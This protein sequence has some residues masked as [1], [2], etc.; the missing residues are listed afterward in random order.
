M[1]SVRKNTLDCRVNRRDRGYAGAEYIEGLSKEIRKKKAR[2]W[3]L[4]NHS[5]GFVGKL[6][7]RLTPSSGNV[8][9]FGPFDR[10]VRMECGKL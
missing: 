6:K 2:E 1:T 8:G 7:L 3:F 5:V 4:S 10:R 9:L